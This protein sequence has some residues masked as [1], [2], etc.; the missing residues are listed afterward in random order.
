MGEVS[1]RLGT[2]AFA[3][4]MRMAAATLVLWLGACGPLESPRGGAAGAGGAAADSGAEAARDGRF[5]STGDAQS[6]RLYFQYVD[7]AGRVR[8]T[9]RLEDVP[10]AWRDKVGYVEM[11]AP[12]PLAPADARRTRDERFARSA[13]GLATRARNSELAAQVPDRRA[14][15]IELFYAQWCGYCK[16]ARAHLDRRGA[17]YELRDIDREPN[18]EELVRRTGQ[19]AIPVIDIDG[20]V[21][22]GY[23]ASRLDRMLDAAS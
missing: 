6:R 22:I 9:E 15:E 7:Q 21:L 13:G 19:R 17:A 23:D 2:R 16:R 8:F 3:I 14:P 4:P 5:A 10:E 12:P 11:D 18:G 1:A 20:K